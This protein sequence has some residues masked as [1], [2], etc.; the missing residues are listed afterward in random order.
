MKER[1]RIVYVILIIMTIFLGLGSRRFSASL[2]SFLATYLGDVLWALMIFFIAGLLFKRKGTTWVG[3]RG[4]IFCYLIEISQLY[5]A[6]W[7]DGVRKTTL[8][9]LVLGFG[10]LWSDLICYTIGIVIGVLLE[11]FLIKFGKYT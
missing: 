10:F 11:K 8:G 6:P 1:N 9:A 7:I 4:L 2:P 3:I 5:H